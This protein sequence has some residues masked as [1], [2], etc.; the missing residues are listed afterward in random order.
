MPR[1]GDKI[2]MPSSTAGIT[3]Y[4]DEVKTK[5]EMR[6]EWVVALAI[7]II[8]LEIALQVYGASLFGL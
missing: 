2:R 3:Q 1:G 7:L 8:I 5:I 4:W 6:P